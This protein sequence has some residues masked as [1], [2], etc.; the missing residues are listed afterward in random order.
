MDEAARGIDFLND[1]GVQ[2][3]DIKP[4]N[5][6]LVGGGVKVADFGLA[7]FLEHSIGGNTG[8]MTPAYAAPEFLEGKTTSRS[9][10]YALAVTYYQ[11]RI[12]RLP[13][14]GSIA[15]VYDGHRRR[16]PDLAPFTLPGERTALARALEKDPFKRWATCQEFCRSVEQ[17]Q[18]SCFFAASTLGSCSFQRSGSGPQQP[19]PYESGAAD[20]PTTPAR[21]ETTR[22]KKPPRPPKPKKPKPR[23]RRLK[24]FLRFWEWDARAVVGIFALLGLALITIGALYYGYFSPI[25]STLRPNPLAGP[26]GSA[27]AESPEAQGGNHQLAG[28]DSRADTSGT[29]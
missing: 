25:G 26:G 24:R 15:Q 22:I 4:Q 5:L 7:K 13:F 21:D 11:L 3:R 8:A 1:R 10:E 12:G 19:A 16:Q 23:F 2:H 17:W 18:G 14:T 9:D 27:L 20:A 29:V 28:H 6:L